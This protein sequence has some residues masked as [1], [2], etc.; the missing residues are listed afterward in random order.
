MTPE[1]KA[2]FAV[3]VVEGSQQQDASPAKKDEAL[4]KETEGKAGAAEEPL[5]LVSSSWECN[6]DSTEDPSANHASPNR[7]DSKQK[8][9]DSSDEDAAGAT[10][11]GNT[12]NT[13]TTDCSDKDA[14]TTLETQQDE[15]Q[16][17]TEQLEET[18]N[19][20]SKD[21]RPK[22]QRPQ[23]NEPCPRCH[24]PETKFCYYNNYNIK[25]PRFFCK[26]C[27]RYWTS[28]GTLRAVPPGAGR[29]KSKSAAAREKQQ[30]ELDQLTD[31][32]RQ[33]NFP[34]PSCPFPSTGV[35]NPF[36]KTLNTQQTLL[37]A[38]YK[39]PGLSGMNPWVDMGA[40]QGMNGLD[41]RL[42]SSLPDTLGG[43]GIVPSLSSVASTS[44]FHGPFSTSSGAMTGSAMTCDG[45]GDGRRVCQRME[46]KASMLRVPLGRDSSTEMTHPISMLAN[47]SGSAVQLQAMASAV[48]GNGW[49]GNNSSMM[50]N[51]FWQQQ[52][53]QLA[54]LGNPSWQFS[55]NGCQNHAAISLMTQQL[56]S[57]IQQ[58]RP[59]SDMRQMPNW[60]GFNPNAA[61]VSSMFGTS[62][63]Q[64]TQQ[65]TMLQQLN[66]MSSAS[67][68]VIPVGNGN[69]DAGLLGQQLIMDQ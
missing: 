44:A 58:Q 22:L 42:L 14:M 45:S 15:Q 47:S 2:G 16:E 28:G 57:G 24:S 27:Q 34:V 8:F 55:D 48:A 39:L 69:V 36:L 37:S 17:E 9:A 51:Q 52:K 66:N 20:D 12:G 10:G 25:Q 6:G 46:E 18:E 31:T 35:Q 4:F 54:G 59:Q 64:M 32:G 23:V 67:N 21:K 56:L 43:M 19:Q 41:S 40:V 38:G 53:Q 26:S 50:G 30:H 1:D 3:E 61:A 49:A 13:R 11:T 7:G 68:S 33:T 62:T 60:G 5:P 63:Q 65:M 29:R